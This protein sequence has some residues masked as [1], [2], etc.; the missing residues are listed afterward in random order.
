MMRVLREGW[1][2]AI[3]WIL[4]L[5]LLHEFV[6]RHWVHLQGSDAIQLLALAGLVMN[7]T[8]RRGVEKMKGVAG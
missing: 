2:P 8:W 1:R 6:I 7:E 3:G 5:A 4:A